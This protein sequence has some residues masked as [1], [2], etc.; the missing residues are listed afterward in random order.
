MTKETMFAT[1]QSNSCVLFEGK[2]FHRLSV[3]THLQQT[4]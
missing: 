3:N 2:Q 1:F 4:V